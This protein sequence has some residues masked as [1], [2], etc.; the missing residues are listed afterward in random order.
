[1]LEVQSS[2]QANALQALLQNTDQSSTPARQVTQKIHHISDPAPNI[3]YFLNLTVH[4][5]RQTRL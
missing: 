3:Q 5:I 1:V 2:I 4:H